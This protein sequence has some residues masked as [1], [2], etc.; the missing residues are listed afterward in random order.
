[1]IWLGNN[2]R[3]CESQIWKEQLSLA[4]CHGGTVK[5]KQQQEQRT[6]TI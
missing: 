2:F 1:M 5:V 6:N 4:I 3:T